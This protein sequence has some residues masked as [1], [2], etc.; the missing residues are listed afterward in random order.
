M[1]RYF[2]T[3][4]LVALVGALA[5]GGCG[6]G[7]G[8]TTS[9]SATATATVGSMSSGVAHLTHQPTGGAD[10][11]WDPSTKVLTVK[12]TLTGLAPNSAHS[13]HIH[14][15]TC[16]TSGTAIKPLPNLMADAKGGVTKTVTFDNVATGIPASGW[17]INVHNGSGGDV[18]N[19]M[20]IACADI[21]NPNP[22]PS[23]AQSV[24]VDFH[25]GYGPS[26]NASG[27]ATL[28]IH[29]SNQLVVTVTVSGL[30]PTSTHAVHI[31]TGS[32]QSQGGIAY[33]FPADKYLKADGSGKATETVTFDNVTSIP[34]SGWYVNVHRGTNMQS[35]IDFDPIACGA[36]TAM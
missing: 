14:A 21:A 27:E 5:L 11:S 19:T 2:Q 13:S 35:S 9:A 10:L 4:V 30:E 29:N 16:A 15:G 1:K 22:N 3:L 6:G 7:G 31:H 32:C 25:R 26:Q 18:Y 36:V 17:F 34:T 23:Q 28:A 24:H 33:G 12:I 8:G 20:D